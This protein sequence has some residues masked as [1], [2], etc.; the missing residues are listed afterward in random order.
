[1][2]RRVRREGSDQFHAH[3]GRIE[4]AGAD[5][6]AHGVEH[7]AGVA[8]AIDAAGMNQST[9]GARGA[10]KRFE[11]FFG[12]EAV[13]DDVHFV[14]KIGVEVLP[15]G[16]EAVGDGTDE[17]GGFEDAAFEPAFVG[18]CPA[19]SGAEGVV[20]EGIAEIG[21]P[22]QAAFAA[23]KVPGDVCADG[24]RGGNDGGD[25][26]L[27]AEPFGLGDGV[28]GPDEALV[29]GSDALGDGGGAGVESGPAAG[30]VVGDVGDAFERIDSAVARTNDVGFEAGF[31]QVFPKANGALDPRTVD[32]RKVMG[33]KDTVS[34][35]QKNWDPG[36]RP[37]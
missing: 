30:V 37:C 36:S 27:G 2:E 7:N 31:R 11:A 21:E 26:I 9:V 22:G 28:S 8:H 4:A 29:V 23:G 25:G 19:G 18:S 6:T 14:L 13:P 35:G 5:Q 3:G 10:G 24:G 33:E 16:D 1:M 32:R 15:F 12:I 34:S 17:S 20:G